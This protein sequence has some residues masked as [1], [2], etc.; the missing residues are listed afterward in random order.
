[1]FVIHPDHSLLARTQCVPDVCHDRLQLDPCF[2]RTAIS[3][4]KRREARGT[5]WKLL[6]SDEAGLTLCFIPRLLF[7]DGVSLAS[8]PSPFPSPSSTGY[9]Q[10]G[11]KQRHS[12]ITTLRRCVRFSAHFDTRMSLC[13]SISITDLWPGHSHVPL[14]GCH[15][16]LTSVRRM[17]VHMLATFSSSILL[18]RLNVQLELLCCRLSR[19]PL[20]LSPWPSL[21]TYSA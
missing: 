6:E 5:S 10:H 9:L 12:K 17:Y 2:E 15:L 11:Q 13:E 20:L 16:A 1:M 14:P 19:Y 7:H 3:R 21:L 18:C 8:S 4:V